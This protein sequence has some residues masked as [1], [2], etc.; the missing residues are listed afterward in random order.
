[1][2][3]QQKDGL[4]HASFFAAYKRFIFAFLPTLL[5]FACQQKE[6]LIEMKYADINSGRQL[7][8]GAA[9]RVD[10]TPIDSINLAFKIPG[11]WG[12]SS[13]I[14]ALMMGNSGAPIYLLLGK[15]DSTSFYY[16]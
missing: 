7:P 12:K 2:I 14:A 16:N 6:Y 8:Y 10:L 4:L 1:M 15:S 3:A 9:H 13:L 11:H 5:F